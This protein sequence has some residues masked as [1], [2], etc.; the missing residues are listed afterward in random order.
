[1]TS[2]DTLSAARSRVGVGAGSWAGAQAEA[3]GEPGLDQRECLSSAIAPGLYRP[4]SYSLDALRADLNRFTFLLGGNDSEILLGEDP[5]NARNRPRLRSVLLANKITGP[6]AKCGQ[7]SRKTAVETHERSHA[8]PVR[9]SSAGQPQRAELDCR[10][11]ASSV[12]HD[13]DRGAESIDL[14]LFEPITMSR[15]SR[16]ATANANQACCNPPGSPSMI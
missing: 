5:P 12:S 13:E 16:Y 9:N 8:Q 7:N 2:P 10:R 4:P 3:A 11:S 1:M 14:K 15:L 6:A